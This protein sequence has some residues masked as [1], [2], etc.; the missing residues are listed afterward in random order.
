MEKTVPM[1]P[2][3]YQ[4]NLNDFALFLSVMKNPRAYRN[5]LSIIMD[6]PDIEIKEVKVEPVILNKSGKR[7]IRLNAWARSTD[8]RQFNM[9][10]QKKRC[11]AEEIADM[12]EEEIGV[13]QE[14]IE[15]LKRE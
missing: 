9:E 11:S 4:F 14:I 10:M 15:E 1:L 6:E 3:D 5:V 2:E 8:E 7:A 13:I 12:L